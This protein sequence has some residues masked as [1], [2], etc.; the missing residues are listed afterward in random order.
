MEL[1]GVKGKAVD[2][3]VTATG[4]VMTLAAN[5]AWRSAGSRRQRSSGHNSSR[6]RCSGGPADFLKK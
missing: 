4:T 3:I 2:C 5:G 6:S 1:C